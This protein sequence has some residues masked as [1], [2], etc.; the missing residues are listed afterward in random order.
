MTN[1]AVLARY[2]LTDEIERLQPQNDEAGRR[3]EI[4]VKEDDL[5]VTLVTMRAGIQ[6]DE[7]SVPVSLSIQVLSGRFEVTFDGQTDTLGTGQFIA[8]KKGTSHAVRAVEDGA[9]LLTLGWPG[10]D[11]E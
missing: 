7:H 2:S 8:L 6:L 1:N 5:R 3:A 10:T 11:Q 9:F 4:L